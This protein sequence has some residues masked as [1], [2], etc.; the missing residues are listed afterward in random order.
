MQA[1]IIPPRT[2]EQTEELEHVYRTASGR[3]RIRALMVLLSTDRHLKVPEIA[4]IVR[5]DEETVRRWLRRY[6]T[7]GIQGLEDA[8]KSGTPPKVTSDYRE[9]LLRVARQRPRAL[10]LPFS[11]W[12]GWRLAD[13]LAEQT[14][15]RLS[16]VTVN[17]MLHQAGIHWNRPQHTITSPDPEYA[18]KKKRS[19]KR[20]MV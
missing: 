9:I 10:D 7:E 12:T 11:L 1:L 3:V 2:P 4:V 16:P 19:S 14:G 8:P 18:V 5:H 15:L 17:R 6:R 20:V 13:D